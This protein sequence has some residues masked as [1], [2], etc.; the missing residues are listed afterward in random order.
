MGFVSEIQAYWVPCRPFSLPSSAGWP[1]VAEPSQ[2]WFLGRL[3]SRRG[4]C[5]ARFSSP[6][7]CRVAPGVSS[8][9]T[10]DLDANASPSTFNPALRQFMTRASVLVQKMAAL[11]VRMAVW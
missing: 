11:M 3:T 2:P 9:R 10:Y 8:P 4:S 5:T 6:W 7:Q 1:R